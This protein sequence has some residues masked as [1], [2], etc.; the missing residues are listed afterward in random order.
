M[1]PHERT[2]LIIRSLLT[3]T[4]LKRK[5]TNKETYLELRQLKV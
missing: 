2:P 3:L 5:E 1:K 4:G